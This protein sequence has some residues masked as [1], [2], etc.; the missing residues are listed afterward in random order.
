LLSVA[1]MN[2]TS[3]SDRL[4]L[5]STAVVL[6][7]GLATA[8]NVFYMVG[9]AVGIFLS[10]RSVWVSIR[11]GE[12]GSDVLALIAIVAAG[13]ISEWLA[14]SIIALMLA[15]GRALEAWAAGRASDQLSA[16]VQRAPRRIQ[17][18]GSDGQISD[19]PIANVKV[20]NAFL[21]RTGEVV[22]VDGTLT[23]SATFDESALTGEPLPKNREIGEEVP[24]GVVN[25]G[26]SVRLIATTTAESST[27]ASLVRLVQNAKAHSAPGV[28]IANKY[29]LW[30]VPLSVVMALATWVVTGQAEPAIAVIVA[31]TPCPLILA[32][33]IAIIAGISNAAKKGAIIKDGAALE[34]LAR[35]RVL[36]VDKT[37]TLTHGGPE[38]SKV[39]V[40]PSFTESQVLELAAGMEISSAHVLAKAIVR[41]AETRGCKPAVITQVKEV[42]GEGL[43]GDYQGKKLIVGRLPKQLPS[44]AQASTSLQV[45]VTLEG[46]LIGVIDLDDPIRPDAVST[47]ANLRELGV[48]KILLVTGDRKP[49]AEAVGNAVGVDEIHA[50]CRPEDKLA[51]VDRERVA[52]SG[53]VLVVGDG[54][55]DSPALAAADVGVAMGARGATAASETASVVIIEDSI[56]RLVDA[57]AISQGARGRALQSAFIG[58]GLSLVTMI[59]GAVGITNVT[60]NAIAQEVI[61]AAAILWALVPA[62]SRKL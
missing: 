19:E 15:T 40:A 41:G 33:P 38:I 31:A 37:G 8:A 3:L 59:L 22:P 6:V 27:Y 30:F 29:A 52:N 45:A 28:R 9:A 14:A 25:A 1:S 4:V 35:S 34:K 26:E 7:L 50:E 42:L 32:I 61:D 47:I 36:L 62:R 16:L 54:I 10:I 21:V 51:L 2:K 43:G 24:S 18:V 57:I 13:F 39:S 53:S 23:E 48:N 60:E 58:M 17:L 11:E 44:W 49:A 56:S 5:L 46:Q 12:I 20:G 55:N